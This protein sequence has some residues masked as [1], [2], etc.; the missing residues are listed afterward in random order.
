MCSEK[1]K[2]INVN[3]VNII[4]KT[5]DVKQ[6][7]NIFHLVVNANSIVQHVIQIKNG[8]M[9]HVNMSVKFIISA[10]KILVGILA[11]ACLRIASIQK[12]LL[13]LQ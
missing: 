5:N 6:W 10:K 11:H 3:V 13:I 1:N 8:I 9:K 2:R 4:T 12:V 7:Q